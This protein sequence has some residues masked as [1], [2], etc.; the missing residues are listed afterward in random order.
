[1]YTYFHSLCAV[2]TEGPSNLLENNYGAIFGISVGALVVTIVV[3]MSL[4]VILDRIFRVISKGDDQQEMN[5]AGPDQDQSGSLRF[6]RQHVRDSHFTA[7]REE[8]ENASTSMPQH[9]ITSVASGGHHYVTGINIFSGIRHHSASALVDS[10][11]NST[12]FVKNYRRHNSAIAVGGS[13]HHSGGSV[14]VASDSHCT[15]IAEVHQNPTFEDTV[16]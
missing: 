4:I 10:S 15:A 1:M 12:D 8:E 6:V 7:V 13:G 11:Y 2:D 14:S 3:C 5:S 16:L 9:N